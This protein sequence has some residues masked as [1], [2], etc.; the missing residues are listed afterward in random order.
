MKK[1]GIRQLVA[2]LTLGPLLLTMLIAFPLYLHEQTTHMD[3]ALQQ[4]G[5]LIAQQLAWS[6]VDGLK[7]AILKS[8]AEGAL[9]QE[10]VLS[11]IILNA[12]SN[13]LISLT[14]GKEAEGN[15][16]QSAVA[17]LTY[18]DI[19]PAIKTDKN[20]LLI[21]QPITQEEGLRAAGKE[22]D[23]KPLGMVIVELSRSATEARKSEFA[24]VATMSASAILIFL[25]YVI[26]LLSRSIARPVM[27]LS[28]ATRQ[29]P[30]KAADEPI[31]RSV[32]IA[33]FENII[34]YIKSLEHELNNMREMVQHKIEEATHTL[35]TTKLAAERANYEKSR[36][37]AAASHDLR[38][39]IH[40]LGLYA[41][42]LQRRVAS[43][44]QQLVKKIEQSIESLSSLINALLDISKFDA[45]VIAPNF[46]N[47]E[48]KMLLE[49]IYSDYQ[50]LAKIKNIR[51]VVRPCSSYVTADPLL[52][53]RVLVNL[54]SN[55]IHYTNPGGCVLV[56]CRRRGAYL[57]FE[58]HDNGIGIDDANQKNIFRE[59]FQIAQSHYDTKEGLGLGLS[60]VERISKLL[61]YKIKVC[62]KPGKGSR[63]SFEVPL[64]KPVINLGVI[65][66][67]LIENEADYY[68][69]ALNGKKILVVDD[70]GMVLSSTASLLSSWG[71]EVDAAESI[72]QVAQFIVA[73][74]TWDLIITDYQLANDISGFDVIAMVHRDTNS[75]LTPCILISGDTSQAV[76][77]IANIS[78]YQLIHK[79]VRP[80]KLKGVVMQAIRTKERLVEVGQ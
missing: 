12:R 46:Q 33:E 49:R 10:D 23:N 78:G 68:S 62:S 54:V 35:Q 55:A 47:Y 63:F 79:P 61:G 80:A 74:H 27:G 36:F 75:Q 40:A 30:G 13:V 3:I 41:T 25:L 17:G 77:K 48:V 26:Y 56:A 24:W 50:M 45:G 70:D 43:K 19:K 32:H 42:E 39:P 28:N 22:I 20:R 14:R 37:L 1:I 59:F 57:R 9:R 73:G 4:R 38:Q 65:A 66:S 71:C 51:F 21:Y 60:I 67:P 53:E 69:D 5:K 72:D 8:L 6:S 76:L 44:E 34:K 64:A 31:F 16:K 58:I 2:A 11:V 18:P 15:P 52:L 7:P 29:Q